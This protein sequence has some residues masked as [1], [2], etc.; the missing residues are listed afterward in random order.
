MQPQRRG[1]IFRAASGAS[2][3]VPFERAFPT[4]FSVD[5]SVRETGPG[6]TGLGLRRFNKLS[7]REYINCS[8]LHCSGKALALGDLLREMQGAG[9]T[10][11]HRE[12][13]CAGY[14]ESGD[15]CPNRFQ[16]ELT[17]AYHP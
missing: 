2:E 15:P 14:Q 10:S 12:L 4:I 17:V 3:N 9:L 6:N 5:A 1:S 8:N 13:S 16:I 11:V 7:L